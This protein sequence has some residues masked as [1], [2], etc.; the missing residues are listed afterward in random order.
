VEGSTRYLVLELVLPASGDTAHLLRP[1]KPR[2]TVC[3]RRL[4]HRWTRTGDTAS[5]PYQVTGVC[6]RCVVGWPTEQ[7]V[8]GL[9]DQQE[10][11]S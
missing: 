5:S 10:V 6:K 9:D 2:R 8:Y 1:G 4:D 11:T 3:G 7:E